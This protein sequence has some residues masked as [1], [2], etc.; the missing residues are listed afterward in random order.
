MESDHAVKFYPVAKDH[1]IC[2][3]CRRAVIGSSFTFECFT[4]NKSHTYYL[5]AGTAV[6]VECLAAWPQARDFLGFYFEAVLEQFQTSGYWMLNTVGDEFTDMMDSTECLA[7]DPKYDAQEVLH[8]LLEL[9]HMEC[10]ASG[11]EI[12]VIWEA[13]GEVIEYEM[14]GTG[15]WSGA[16]LTFLCSP[17]T[18]LI[19][20]RHLKRRFECIYLAN[21]DCGI[22]APDFFESVYVNPTLRRL[23]AGVN[24]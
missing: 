18:F 23:Q 22:W 3:L 16:G 11:D 10:V 15:P 9:G 17:E 24:A 6:H 14:N 4:C 2:A 21:T 12:R 8:S 5:L 13:Q 7:E 1:S 20:W 19:H